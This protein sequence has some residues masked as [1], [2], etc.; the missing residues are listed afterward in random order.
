MPITSLDHVNLRTTRLDAMVAW[1]DDIL[2]LRSEARPDFG[3]PGAWIYAG[4]RPAVHLIGVDGPEATGSETDLKLEHF[5]FSAT[6]LTEFEALLQDRG[7]R[8][9]RS[10]N[11][12]TGL[13]QMNVWDPD[14]NHIHVDFPS[15]E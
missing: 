2:G 3:S 15:D 6:G 10:D 1:Y 14:G 8:Y 9:R 7:E 13:V 12:L 4:G 11:P 5:A